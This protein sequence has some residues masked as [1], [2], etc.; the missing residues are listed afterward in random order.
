MLKLG[1][2]PWCLC[3][4]LTNATVQTNIPIDGDLKGYL[5]GRSTRTFQTPP[6]YGAEILYVTQQKIIYIQVREAQDNMYMIYFFTSLNSYNYY[7][8]KH[9][10]YTQ[11]MVCHH[12]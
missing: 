12:Y 7:H 5:S 1:R 11:N 9:Q 2:I 3:K 4:R 8:K 10:I 6:S